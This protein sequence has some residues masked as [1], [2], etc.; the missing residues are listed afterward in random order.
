MLAIS[1]PL[2]VVVS[3]ARSSATRDQFFF[4]ELIHQ[5]SESSKLLL[6]RS[7]LATTKVSASRAST[8]SIAEARPGRPER[9]FP[10]TPGILK[11]ADQLPVAASPPIAGA[12]QD[13]RCSRTRRTAAGPSA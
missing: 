13:S 10:E 8:V 1:S 3:I 7:S 12:R 5:A 11:D 6:N 2:G 9:D 4:W